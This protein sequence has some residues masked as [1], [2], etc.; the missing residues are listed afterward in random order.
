MHTIIIFIP[1]VL[2]MALALK[3]KKMAESMFAAAFA[4]MLILHGRNFANGT[5]DSFYQAMSS[6]SFQFVLL[7]L[8]GFGGSMQILQDSGALKGFGKLVSK[9]ASGQKKP[10][11]LT[12]I[13][14][15][16]M[17]VEDFLST[18][19]LTF[20]M[21]S[22]FDENRIPREHLAINTIAV[23]ASLCVLIPFSSW[24]AF[25]MGLLKEYGLGF[26]E[27]AAA[28]RY[29][30]YPMVIIVILL[31]LALGI[32][33]KV[34]AL[35]ESYDRVAA[36]GPTLLQ[37]ENMESLV[38]LKAD[39]N[40]KASSAWNALIP[41]ASIIA[42]TIYFDNDVVHGIYLSILVEFVMFIANRTMTVG[43][44]FRSFF[45]G[46]KGMLT[47]CILV[48]L[49]FL[50][51]DANKEMGVFD[52]MIHSVADH[53]PVQ[54]LP[55]VVFLLMF[56]TTFATAGC[57]VMQIIAVPIFIPMA[58]AV[59]CPPELVI[60]PMMSGVVVGYNTCFYG[61]IMFLCSAGTGVPNLRI[62]KTL[63]PYA[64]AAGVIAAAGFAV[65]G[66]MVL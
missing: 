43:E 31:L 13:L 23:S 7:I 2:L 33:P 52:I 3:T 27:Y 5:I 17:F 58:L 29:M 15:L 11:L 65:L 66:F 32:V 59:G 30:F 36:G 6:A 14:A 63:S 60:A 56:F 10:I 64:I 19:A 16:T 53:V 18:L 21:S 39:P 46:A 28:I 42:G 9:Y 25:T 34:G 62:V 61:D 51:S 44:F 1:L 4:A 22:V 45:E 35:K 47:I 48:F 8:I 41:I 57:W 54:I 55:L 49:G 38:D 37:E 24:T 12:F 50:L 40:Q 26:P 20:S